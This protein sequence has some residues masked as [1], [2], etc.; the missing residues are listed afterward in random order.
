MN[1][2]QMR[3]LS[4]LHR[5]GNISGTSWAVAVS[6]VAHAAGIALLPSWQAESGSLPSKPADVR[7]R[8]QPL[9]VAA[10]EAPAAAVANRRS[11]DSSLAAGTSRSNAPAP[12]PV[13]HSHAV[14]ESAPDAMAVRG[15]A[16]T[17]HHAAVQGPSQQE[18]AAANPSAIAGDR[19]NAVAT[20]APP[21]R[22]LLAFAANHAEPARHTDVSYLYNPKP[23]YPSMARKLGLEGTVKLRILVNQE[24][25][26]EQSRVLDSSGTEVLDAAALEAVRRWRFVPAREGKVT[27]A[28]WVD[29]PVTFKLGAP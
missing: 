14:K 12:V 1:W 22:E 9:P 11:A 16:P 19:G 13:P 17:V 20:T 26:P 28:H 23:A 29:I 7:I 2:L 27:V 25:V 4:S 18:S 10:V 3:Y 15:A 6:L 5:L 21:A 8:L 24:G